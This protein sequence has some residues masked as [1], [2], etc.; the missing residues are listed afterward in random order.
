M[1]THP[2]S[3]LLALPFLLAA[4]VA[5]AIID[6]TDGFRTG[7]TNDIGGSGNNNHSAAI[8]EYND[9]TNASM[10][11]GS[12]NTAVNYGFVSGSDSWLD[13]YSY[14]CITGGNNNS[15][16][17]SWA[18]AVFG[19]WNLIAGQN[20]SFAAGTFNNINASPGSS[21]ILL[22]HNN[23][24]LGGGGSEIVLIGS[25]NTAEGSI[26]WALGEGNIAQNGTVT[27]GTYAAK[28]SNASLIV[29]KGTS[30]ARSNALVVLKSGAVSIPGSLTIGGSPAAT[31]SY[32]STNKYLQKAG[33]GA[34]AHADAYL[35]FGVGAW[36][37]GAGSLAIG[38]ATTTL[39]TDSIALGRDAT[40]TAT[41][42]GSAALVGGMTSGEYSLAAQK[43]RALGYAST[44]IG[45][46][47]YLFSAEGNHASGE[48]SIA[49]GGVE[50]D[51]EGFA[52][53]AAGAFTRANTA[54]SFALGSLN[55]GYSGD[56][57]SWVESDVLLE[58]GNGASERASGPPSASLR[59]NAITTLKN[60]ET[61]LTNKAWKA[62]VAG[63]GDPLEDPP[64]TTTDSVG[65]ALVVEGHTELKGKVIISEAQGD[66]SMGIYE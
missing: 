38:V 37:T 65:R 2:G 6:D 43:G 34:F 41:A 17:S 64:A 31:A 62:N 47:D 9:A 51:A 57:D 58:I 25:G 35:A 61:T 60:G 20:H 24:I 55:K 50:N 27:L 36:A 40:T 10:A 33:P 28:V 3:L 5:Q 46:Y 12:G 59:S 21:N 14:D 8:G 56:P 15:I 22:G 7:T 45:G 49:I 53:F 52:S 19:A 26:A 44:A 32:L 66:I 63:S 18:T 48:N 39:G 23:A 16:E 4:N 29:G 1:K 13:E 30:S 54:Y 11:V 42:F